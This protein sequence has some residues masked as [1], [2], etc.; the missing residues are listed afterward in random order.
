M[1]FGADGWENGVVLAPTA[2]GG[3][4][5]PTAYGDSSDVKAD[6]SLGRRLSVVATMIG[7]GGNG[8]VIKAIYG[9][10]GEVNKVSKY[11][12]RS[13]W[14][15]IIN[16]VRKLKD[17]GEYLAWKI[18]LEAL[19][20]RFIIRVED[21]DNFNS[22]IDNPGLIDLPLGGRLFTWMN[23][24]RTKLCKLDRFLISKEVAEALPDVHVTAID[25]LWSDHNHILLHVS[26][27]DFGT[28][29]FKLFHSWLLRDSFDKSR[30]KW[31]IEC[32]ENSKNFHGLINQKMRAQMIQ[33]RDHDSN[34]DF[35]PFSNSF[36][37]CDIDRDSLETPVSLDEVK[38]AV[39]DCGSSKAPG[40]DGACLSSSRASILVNGSHTS[41][42]S[43]KRDLRQRDHLSPFL[44]IL[45]MEGSHN[46]LSIV[47]S[48]GLIASN[49]VLL[50]LL[51]SFNLKINIQKS[52]IYGIGVSDVDVSSMASNSG[53]ALGSFPFTYLGLPIGSNTSLT[54]S[55]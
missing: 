44:F 30:V 17:Q 50:S 12:S 48:S 43:I 24:A 11:A 36:G 51:L 16:E 13:C 23:K 32:E 38:N 55:W 14:R 21:A 49:A 8:R 2:Y 41:E 46:A 39:W 22:F 42:V 37:L 54:S 28:T 33:F 45:I 18:K 29:P 1:V 25:R 20:T 10:D 52:N 7:G 6:S 4:V 3:V 31:D 27:S 40:L 19:P 53:C 34:V 47:V 9:D 35:P 15:D 5:A 26:K